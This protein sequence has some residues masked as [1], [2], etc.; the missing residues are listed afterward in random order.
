MAIKTG[1]GEAATFKVYLIDIDSISDIN[2]ANSCVHTPIYSPGYLT[3]KDDKVDIV[4][5]ISCN[6]ALDV[7]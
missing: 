2:R 6:H 3:F 5:K 4:S 7:F 1:S